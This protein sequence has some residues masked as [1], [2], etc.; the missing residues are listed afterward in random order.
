MTR[1]CSCVREPR[2]ELSFVGGVGKVAGRRLADVV[3]EVER[4]GDLLER[5]LRDFEEEDHVEDVPGNPSSSA[6][7]GTH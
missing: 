5:A 1:V 7:H 4:L 6:C 2:V 3:V